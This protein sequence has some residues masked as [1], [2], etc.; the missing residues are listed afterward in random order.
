[1]E[2]KPELPESVPEP[3]AQTN[4]DAVPATAEPVVDEPK[5]LVVGESLPESLPS[6]EVDDSTEAAVKSVSISVR[7]VCPPA[8]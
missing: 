2:S 4:G 3:G 5:H 1:M 7:G 8:C 6:L